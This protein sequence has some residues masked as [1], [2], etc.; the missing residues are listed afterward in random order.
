[1][2]ERLYQRDSYV[3]EFDALVV[4]KQPMGKQIGLILDHTYFYPTA[5]GQQS[6]RG[7]IDNKIIIDVKE[8]G[9]EIIH[10]VE[11]EPSCER[12]HCNVDWCRRFSFMQQHTGQHILSQ[13]FVELEDAPT[14]SAHM[15]EIRNTID[16]GIAGLN[17]DILNKVEKYANEI[18]MKMLPVNIHFYESIQECPFQLR[19]QPVVERKMRVVEISTFDANACGGTHCRNTGE[20][21][22]I[23]VLSYEKYKGGYRI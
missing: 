6:D 17:W 13:C 14:L 5:G 19:K 16:L 8:E 2:T 22:V 18:V 3:T 9:N 11:E 20:V 12:V 7:T 10:V 21:G 1:M 4:N 15:G 23:K